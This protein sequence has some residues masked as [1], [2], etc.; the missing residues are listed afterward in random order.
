MALSFAGNTRPFC[1]NCWNSTFGPVLLFAVWLTGCNNTCFTFTSNPPTGM[2]NVKV[3]NPAPTCTLTK[4][5]GAIRSTVK[6]IPRC[7]WLSAGPSRHKYRSGHRIEARLGVVS[8][9]R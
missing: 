2:L 9:C 8:I 1:R 4:A 5:N 6:K 3:S 7:S